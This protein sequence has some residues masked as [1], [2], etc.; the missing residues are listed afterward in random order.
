MDYAEIIA[1]LNEEMNTIEKAALESWRSADSINEREF[2]KIKRV[3]EAKL[4]QVP[5]S[6][7]EEVWEKLRSRMDG[8]ST[9]VGKTTMSWRLATTAAIALIAIGVWTFINEKSG[10]WIE[11]R[12]TQAENKLEHELKD[13][14]L[15]ELEPDAEVR[16]P[17]VFEADFREVELSGQAR[18][19]V[20]HN[21]EKPLVVKTASNTVQVLGT[22]FDLMAHPDSQRSWVQLHEGKVRFSSNQQADLSV[23]LSAGQ[24]AIFDFRSQHFSLMD[25]IWVSYINARDSVY[26]I[27]EA[28]VREF[29]DFLEREYEVKIKIESLSFEKYK[30]QGKFPK[31]TTLSEFMDV[32]RILFNIEITKEGNLYTWKCLNCSD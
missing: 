16:Y 9:A 15:I 19:F 10:D 32:I 23:E 3:W 20:A 11:V 2:Q 1:Y 14:T 21:S 4:E 13:G 12:N 27:K 5:D 18:F 29:A 8:G 7:P 25:S 26:V 31:S 6:D 17:A 22:A 30:M 28:S 24:S